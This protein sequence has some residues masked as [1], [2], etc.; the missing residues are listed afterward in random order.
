M[1]ISRNAKNA[2]TDTLNV[3]GSDTD[4]HDGYAVSDTFPPDLSAGTPG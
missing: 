1:K 2:L 3:H 4:I